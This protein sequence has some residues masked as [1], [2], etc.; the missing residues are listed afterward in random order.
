MTSSTIDVTDDFR[1][2]AVTIPT[3]E[4]WAAMRASGHAVATLGDDGPVPRLEELG[5]RLSGKE[6]AAFVVTGTAANL[7]ALMTHTRPGEQVIVD[8]SCHILWSEESSLAGICGLMPGVVPLH[9][10]VVQPDAIERLITQHTMG[11]RRRTSLV[12]LEIPHTG[13]GGATMTPEAVAAVAAVAHEHGAAVHVDGA[14]IFNAC[15]HLGVPLADLVRPVDSVMISLNKGLSAPAGALL[16]GSQALVSGCRM[17]LR[18]LGAASIHSGAVWATAGLVALETMVERLADDHRLAEGLANGLI[19]VAGVTVNARTV[20][21]NVVIA[22][23]HPARLSAS[24]VCRELRKRRVGALA[25]NSSQVRFVTHRHLS[26][27]SIERLIAALND[28]LSSRSDRDAP[29]R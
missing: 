9:G 12:C 16:C 21:T 10:G 8:A 19:G 25:Y 2:D 18:R 17:N 4:M 23:I 28:I 3:D 15:V 27:A 1:T 26:T 6:A 24:D 13:S 29:P 11:H 14:R 22:D 20:Q 7:A 5:A